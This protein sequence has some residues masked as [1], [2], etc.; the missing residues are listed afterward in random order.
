MGRI[1]AVLGTRLVRRS[2]VLVLTAALVVVAACSSGDDTDDSGTGTS[3]SGSA[4]EVEAEPQDFSGPGPYDVGEVDLQLD[5]D[6]KI[7]VFYPVDEVPTGAEP[8]TYS[9]DSIFGPSISNLLPGA[10]S[11]TITIPDTYVDAPPS[12]DGP[13]P[14]VLH[15]HG[16]SGN[17]RFGN[18]HNA[19]VASWGYVVAAVDHPERGVVSILESFVSGSDSTERPD[20]Y[21]DS[22]Q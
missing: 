2:L 17:L 7:A 4:D 21:L 13:F 9:G 1:L 22:D 16:F 19:A 12:T 11:D 20:E 5:P 10:L 14:V 15:S 18:R 8:Y 3:G 6:H